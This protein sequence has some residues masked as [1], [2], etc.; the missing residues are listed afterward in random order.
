MKI[1]GTIFATYRGQERE[2]AFVHRACEPK[3]GRDHPMSFKIV[4]AV[5]ARM[6]ESIKFQNSPRSLLI[7]A[8]EAPKTEL[9]GADASVREN[10][11]K[12]LACRAFESTFR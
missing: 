6:A 11:M 8:G 12:T 4:P 10:D 3:T 9:E 5:S 2:A 1:A 7:D